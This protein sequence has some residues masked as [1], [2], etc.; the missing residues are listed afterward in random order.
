MP[1]GEIQRNSLYLTEKEL[2]GIPQIFTLA[3]IV[4]L[5]RMAQ[6]ILHLK[7]LIRRVIRLIWV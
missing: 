5:G 1:T 3:V 7:D 2:S 6:T 4:I